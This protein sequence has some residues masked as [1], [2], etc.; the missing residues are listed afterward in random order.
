MAG[1]ERGLQRAGPAGAEVQSGMHGYGHTHINGDGECGKNE[2]GML[3]SVVT[4]NE[5]PVTSQTRS[6]GWRGRSLYCM[7]DIGATWGVS[8]GSPLT[9][10]KTRST[11]PPL[12]YGTWWHR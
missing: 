5:T 9:R 1:Q 2:K 8:G 3:S 10:R 4:R 7:W 11:R 6:R 12:L